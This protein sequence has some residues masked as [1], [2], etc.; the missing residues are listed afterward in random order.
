MLNQVGPLND[1]VFEMME[2]D[3]FLNFRV[4]G[5]PLS[6]RRG[7][8][9]QG[10]LGSSERILMDS[11]WGQR[12]SPRSD[13]LSLLLWW[14]QTLQ[15]KCKPSTFKTDGLATDAYEPREVSM[16]LWK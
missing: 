12:F 7:S 14:E 1:V 5:P 4:L 15:N 10:D 6:T 16:T 9:K 2:K 11:N 8:F 13:P 3:A